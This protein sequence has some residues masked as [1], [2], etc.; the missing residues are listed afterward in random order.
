[1]SVAY[2][3]GSFSTRLAAGGFPGGHPYQDGGH[4]NERRARKSFRRRRR[5]AVAGSS[6]VLS[7]PREQLAADAVLGAETPGRHRIAE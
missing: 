3:P 6:P 5:P 4:E 7:G 2:Y 1:M